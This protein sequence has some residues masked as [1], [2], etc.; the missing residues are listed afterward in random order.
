[1]PTAA[2]AVKRRMTAESGEARK[3][4]SERPS[5]IAGKAAGRQC[6]ERGA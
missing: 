4:W 5:G 6:G 3:G 2:R 1:M